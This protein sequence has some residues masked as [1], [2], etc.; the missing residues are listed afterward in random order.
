M[1]LKALLSEAPQF[2][3]GG[4]YAIQPPVLH[5]IAA[6]L[7]E[8]AHTLET[9]CGW[10]T[11]VLADLA[12]RHTCISPL[13]EEHVSVAEWCARHDVATEHVRFLPD[14]S[15]NVIHQ[16]SGPL[17]LVLIDGDHAFPAPFIDWYYTADRLKPGGVMIVDDTQIPTGR[18]LKNF[19]LA[20]TER[21][22][23]LETLGKTSIFRR[24]TEQPV[25]QGVLWIHQPWCRVP[26]YR[27]VQQSIRW[28]LRSQ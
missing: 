9:G 19:L 2:H 7:P 16:L 3:A 24:I 5:W 8:N 10:S 14:L 4:Q 20:E 17:D 12:E 13:A 23:L 1:I 25:A 15:Q 22:E 18:T 6:Y 28:R 11:I 26:L 21:W 27:R